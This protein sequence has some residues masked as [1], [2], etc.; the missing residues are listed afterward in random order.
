MIAARLGALDAEA[1]QE[2]LAKK[3]AEL[4]GVLNGLAQKRRDQI[5]AIK[6]AAAK[7][8]EAAQL[9]AA[10][11]AMNPAI[12]A[13]EAEEAKSKQR[14]MKS[15]NAIKLLLMRRRS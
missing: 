7:M 11:E 4:A 15:R 12:A 10:A 13:A 3:E 5:A 2:E 8:A 6:T 9:T 1:A 14:L